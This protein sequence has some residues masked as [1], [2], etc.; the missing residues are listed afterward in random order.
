MEKEKS[1][2]EIG[3]EYG[4]SSSIFVTVS[5]VYVMRLYASFVVRTIM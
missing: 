2:T 3:G 4:Y 1:I 5:F